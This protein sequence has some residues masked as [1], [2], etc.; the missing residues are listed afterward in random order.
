M[1][2]LNYI[3]KFGMIGVNVSITLSSGDFIMSYYI[4]SAFW[5]VKDFNSF[6]K[7]MNQV[8]NSLHGGANGLYSTDQLITFGRNLTFLGDDSFIKAFSEHAKTEMEKGLIWRRAIHYWAAAH[9]LNLEGDFVECGVWEGTTVR[10]LY[11]AINFADSGKYYWLYDAFDFKKGDL[12]HALPGLED[13]LYQRVVDRFAF[14]PNV[15]IIQGYIPESFEKGIPAQVSLLHID[16]NNALAEI[17]ALEMLWQK[18]VP[19]GI[20]LLDDFGWAAYS[21]QTFAEI[22]FFKSR[23][24]LVFELPTGQGLVIKR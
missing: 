8:V 13:G 11:D 24:Y 22:D 23:G 4:G 18:V 2:W 21:E 15:K 9:C 20:C 6:A 12:H 14:A 10:I 19:G 17:A 7:G 3:D 5:G 16:M 1:R